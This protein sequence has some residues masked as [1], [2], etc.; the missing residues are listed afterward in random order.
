MKWVDV[1]NP[2]EELYR[3]KMRKISRQRRDIIIVM[4]CGLVTLFAEPIANQ[5]L[6]AP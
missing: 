4:L 2:R 3:F 1:L 5:I 6:G